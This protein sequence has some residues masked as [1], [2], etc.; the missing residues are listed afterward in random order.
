MWHHPIHGR[1]FGSHIT[2][3][4]RALQLEANGYSVVV[5]ELVGFEHS[6]KNELIVATNTNKPNANAAVKL[7]ELLAV[8]GLIELKHRFFMAE[9][10]F[11]S[12]MQQ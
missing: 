7:N 9:G 11:T 10:K 6:M 3:V 4:L 12:E 5:T 1:E 8:L 2:N